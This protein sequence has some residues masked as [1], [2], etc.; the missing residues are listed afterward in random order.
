MSD[1]ENS[2][3]GAYGVWQAVLGLYPEVRMGKLGSGLIQGGLQLTVGRSL[4]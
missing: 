1:C 3:S 2:R 4:M